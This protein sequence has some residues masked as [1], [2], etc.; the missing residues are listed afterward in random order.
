MI[1]VVLSFVPLMMLFLRMGWEAL[2]SALLV[3][4]ELLD[5]F[6]WS[7]SGYVDNSN[8][9]YMQVLKDCK[10]Y[11][12]STGAGTFGVTYGSWLLMNLRACLSILLF[13]I[14]AYI[15]PYG[16]LYDLSDSI[17]DK[18]DPFGD[19]VIAV[20]KRIITFINESIDILIIAIFSGVCV[21]LLAGT[22]IRVLNFVANVIF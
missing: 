1:V 5:I 7:A 9:Y 22:A 14:F 11:L 8:S 12:A 21:A 19:K 10:E 6:C 13:G 2:K 17:L 16:D 18:E 4:S 3:L 15:L 20:I